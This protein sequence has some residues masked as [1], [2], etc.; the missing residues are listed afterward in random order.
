MI[1]EPILGLFSAGGSGE[2]RR[3]MRSREDYDVRGKETA[4]IFRDQSSFQDSGN[5]ITSTL[6]LFK[7]VLCI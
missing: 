2:G 5:L 7:L 1:R 6:Q 4:R 3:K